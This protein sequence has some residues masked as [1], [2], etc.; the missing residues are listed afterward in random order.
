M[1]NE[2]VKY[3]LQPKGNLKILK[4]IN[5]IILIYKI[6]IYIS[7]LR[8]QLIEVKILQEVRFSFIPN[9]FLHFE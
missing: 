7:A 2:S 6:I 1:R 8:A 4:Y 5:Q 9:P 3:K